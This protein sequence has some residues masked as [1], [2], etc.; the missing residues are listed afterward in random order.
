MYMTVN[1]NMKLKD[2]FLY[3]KY[4]KSGQMLGRFSSRRK[5]LAQKV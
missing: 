1:L 4:Q 2:E 5:V 3:S